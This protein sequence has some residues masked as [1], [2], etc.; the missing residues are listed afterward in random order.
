MYKGRSDQFVPNPGDT[1]TVVQI[2]DL[3]VYANDTIY[4]MHLYNYFVYAGLFHGQVI[5]KEVARYM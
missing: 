2:F 3:Y 5:V 4:K 1:L